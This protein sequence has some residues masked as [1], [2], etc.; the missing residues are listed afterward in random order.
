[1]PPLLGIRADHQARIGEKKTLLVEHERVIGFWSNQLTSRRGVR[2][3][4]GPESTQLLLLH[5]YA[6]FFKFTQYNSDIHNA[7]TLTLT[8]YEHTYTNSVP[9]SIF[10]D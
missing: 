9:T 8:P 4:L 5:M 2:I 6:S 7:R 1:M 3:M 10:E